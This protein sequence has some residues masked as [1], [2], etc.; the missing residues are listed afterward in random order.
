MDTSAAT[1][2]AWAYPAMARKITNTDA[3]ASF[4]VLLQESSDAACSLRLK[5]SIWLQRDRN[6]IFKTGYYRTAL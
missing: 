2:G 1:F 5:P 3:M 6:L 4:T